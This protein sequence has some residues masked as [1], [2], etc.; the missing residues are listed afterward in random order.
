M[1]IKIS[2]CQYFIIP[3]GWRNWLFLRITSTDNYS[4]YSEFTES[5]GSEKALISAIEEIDK[6]LTGKSFESVSEVVRAL[7]KKYRQ[8]LPGTL[9]KAISAYENALWDLQSKS[10]NTPISHF[11]PEFKSRNELNS[12]KCYWSHCPTTRIRASHHVGKKKITNYDDLSEVGREVSENGFIAFKT[13]L[14]QISPTPKVL[15]PGFNKEFKLSVESIPDAYSIELRKVLDAITKKNEI[16]II[17]D[18]NFNANL[19]HFRIIQSKLK[20]LNIR[21][22]EIDF[23]EIGTYEKILDIKEFPI[24]TGENT[25]GIFNYESILNDQR[26]DI[27]SIDVLWNGLEESLKIADRAIKLGKKIA[28]HNYYSSLATS[29]ALVFISMLP[30]ESIELLEFDFDDVSWRDDISTNPPLLQKGSITYKA[31]IGWGNDFAES[32]FGGKFTHLPI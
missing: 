27:I 18:F 23:D 7:R 29:I 6:L 32:K 19:E 25:L 3:A 2:S 12:Y 11:F 22:L 4:G 24:C 17:I 30:E 20:G 15:M 21:W 26:V 1:P 10:L 14:V 13:N 31:V 5:N 9:F 28:V 8:A 16:Q